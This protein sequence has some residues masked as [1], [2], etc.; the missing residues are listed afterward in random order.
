MY[1]WLLIGVGLNH[2]MLVLG[3]VWSSV[4]HHVKLM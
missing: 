4:R 3:M 1:V 2:F